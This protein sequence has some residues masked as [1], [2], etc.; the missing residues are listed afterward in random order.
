V[1]DLSSTC[2]MTFHGK[3][4]E[5]PAWSKRSLSKAKYYSDKDVLLGKD[6]IPKTDKCFMRNW[7][8]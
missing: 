6:I 1:T 4:N 7:K 8:R 2:V 3:K 5:L